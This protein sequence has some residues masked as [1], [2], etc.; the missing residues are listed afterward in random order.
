M[1]P[2]SV[3]TTKSEDEEEDDQFDEDHDEQCK[4]IIDRLDNDDAR[5]H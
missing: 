1:L 4:Y 5:Y 3:S 2:S